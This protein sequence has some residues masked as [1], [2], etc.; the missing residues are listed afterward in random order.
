MICDEHEVM[1]VQILK[2][3]L[4]CPNY[5][6]HLCR[7]KLP[8]SILQGETGLD[9]TQC[10]L[11]DYAAKHSSVKLHVEA[12]TIN[13]HTEYVLTQQFDLADL[14]EVLKNINLLCKLHSSHNLS[15]DLR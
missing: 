10:F 6:S 11:A 4:N 3:H 14:T 12:A 2:E 8:I 1:S 5:G 9:C 15:N 13:L 7:C